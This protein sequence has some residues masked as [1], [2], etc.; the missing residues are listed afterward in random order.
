MSCGGEERAWYMYVGRG[1][2]VTHAMGRRRRGT[3][4]GEEE[5][6]WHMSWGGGEGVAHVMERRRVC[7]M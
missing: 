1:E 5:R 6:A 4:H 7:D 3:C 2:H